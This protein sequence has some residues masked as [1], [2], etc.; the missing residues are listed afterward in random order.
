MVG[1]LNL[2]P[3]SFF[4]GGRHHGPEHAAERARRMVEEGASVI[5]LGGEST[6]PGAVPVSPEEERR[7]VLPVLE[8]LEGLPVPIAIDTSDPVLMRAAAERGA[9]LVNDVR[10]L[11]RPGALEAASASGLAV[12]LMHM[13][14]EPPTMQED[15]RYG[16]VVAEVHAFL[17]ARRDAC[18]ASGIGPRSILLDPGFGFGKTLAH[19]VALLRALGR[20]RDLGCPLLVG[21]SRKSFVGTLGGGRSPGERLPASLAAAVLAYASGATFLRVHDVAATRD[22]L[23]F[24]HAVRTGTA[25]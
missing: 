10:A 9:R 4:D 19:N 7:R 23:A 16:D 20:F 12:C 25:A 21:L 17:A 2:T 5:E 11:L 24:A 18:L 15:P 6:R 8:R 22:A 3:D 1:I 13:R 14:G